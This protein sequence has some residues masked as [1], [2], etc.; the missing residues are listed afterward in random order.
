M[1]IGVTCMVVGQLFYACQ[2][3]LEEYILKR[4][5]GQEPCY[6]MG[7]EGIFGL[8]FTTL[9]ILLAQFTGCPFSE[10]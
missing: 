10:E 3:I 8:L 7:W 1:V 9:I 2:N 5:G 6:M 4:A